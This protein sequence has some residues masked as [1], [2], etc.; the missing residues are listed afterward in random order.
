MPRKARK[1][2]GFFES[3]G[4][5]KAMARAARG[6]F[7]EVTVGGSTRRVTPRIAGAARV[8]RFKSLM[9]VCMTSGCNKI[10]GHESPHS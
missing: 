1:E 9:G 5:A 8:D 10:A 7:D 6:D 4:L 2:P 3:F